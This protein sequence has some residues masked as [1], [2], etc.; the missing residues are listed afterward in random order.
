MK[1]S[2]E[3][4]DSLRE[5]GKLIGGILEELMGKAMPGI[6]T[7]ELDNYAE[8]RILEVGG[9]PSFKGYTGGGEKPFPGSVCIS[10]NEELVHGVPG[11]RVLKEGDLVGL[12]IG[13]RYKGLCSDTAVTVAVGKIDSEKQR[14]LDTTYKSMQLGIMK[15]V[16]GNTINDI[17]SAVQDYVEAQG[18]SIVRALVGHGVGHQVHEEPTV[19]N[20]VTKS[21]V[22][23]YTL[24]KGLVIAIEPMV[25]VGGYEVETASD[26]WT[27]VTK[28]GSLS[29]HFEHTVAI[30]ESGPEVLTL[31]PSEQKF[32]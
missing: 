22:G 30:T 16:D 9:K 31:R 28:D 2:K 19:P 10:I 11:T 21:K 14:L 24:H 15:A 5:N 18:F 6:T 3:D 23:E 32:V 4:I 25:N 7:A 29:A 27:V 8:K 13:M 26:G 17:A 20:F 12:D 1:Y